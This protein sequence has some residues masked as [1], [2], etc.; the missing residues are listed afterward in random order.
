MFLCMRD[1][2]HGVVGCLG[3]DG[4]WRSAVTES[5]SSSVSAWLG[6]SPLASSWGC[7]FSVHQGLSG[8]VG[9]KRLVT[10][11]LLGHS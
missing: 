3:D 5:C 4:R 9:N 2:K 11:D 1:G 10:K 8:N 7:L 6:S